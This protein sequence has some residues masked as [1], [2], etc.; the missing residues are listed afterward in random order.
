MKAFSGA[1]GSARVK[2]TSARLT[3]GSSGRVE[4]ANGAPTTLPGTSAGPTPAAASSSA[5]VEWW[6]RAAGRGA[7]PAAAHASVTSVERP[8]SGA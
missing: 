6:A 8:N 7:K 2:A 4:P 3:G 1:V 5:V